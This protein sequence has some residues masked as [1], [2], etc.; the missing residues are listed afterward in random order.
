MELTA[1]ETIMSE[2]FEYSKKQVAERNAVT[3]KKERT[4]LLAAIAVI[5]ILAAGYVTQH[6]LH[7]W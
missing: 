7:W 3:R 4:E 1:Y 6:V 5:G 2:S